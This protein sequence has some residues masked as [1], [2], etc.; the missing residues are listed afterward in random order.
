MLSKTAQIPLIGWEAHDPLITKASFRTKRR[1]INMDVI[2]YFAQT[3][4]SEN[5]DFY[6]RLLTID[7][8]RPK[9]NISLV[10]DDLN[11]KIGS[12]NNDYVAA[13]AR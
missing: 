12:D 3:N 11:T 1:R 6:S 8:N 2:Q 9:R 10:I 5:E 4:N 7:Q 13:R